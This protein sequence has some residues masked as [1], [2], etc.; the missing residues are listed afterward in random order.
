[1]PT[2]PATTDDQALKQVLRALRRQIRFYVVL[3]SLLYVVLLVGALF[4]IGLALDWLLEP[5]P[6]VRRVIQVGV[7][8]VVVAI[9]GWWGLRRLV[10][11]LSDRAMA[12]AIERRHPEFADKLSTAID[13][14]RPRE[15]GHE[16]HPELVART[17]HA[18]AEIAQ[19]IDIAPILDHLRLRRWGAVIVLLSLSV[20]VL[21]VLAPRVWSTYTD[22]LALSP[23]PWPRRVALTVEGFKPDGQ[24]GFV[25]KVARNSDVPI[26]VNARLT[27]ENIAPER[28]TINYRWAN[29]QMGRDDLVRIGEA[30]ETRDTSQ[31][32]EYLFERISDSVTFRL[33]GG[34]DQIRQ[35]RIEVVERPKVTRLEFVCTYPD[36]LGR[37]PR[38]LTVGPQ[39]EIPE[40]TRVAI[41]GTVNKAIDHV[42]WRI[43]TDDE[44]QLP[45]T[46]TTDKFGHTLVVP[47]NN[48]ALEVSLVDKDGIE[49]QEPFR[50]AIQS[51]VDVAPQ[52]DVQRA[53]I[54]LA[55][56]SIARLPLA[57]RLED[58]YALQRA[59][60]EL[61]IDEGASRELPVELPKVGAD[62]A[63]VEA[64]VDLRQLLESATAEAPFSL[65]P[66]NRLHLTAMA[67]DRYNL[68]SEPHH[69]AGRTVT[70]EV[71]SPEDLVARLAASEQS[72]RQTF[73]AIADKLLVLYG[74]LDAM[75]LET[76]TTATPI[77]NA[78]ESAVGDT[79]EPDD[80]ESAEELVA[81]EA[82]RLAENLR[83]MADETAG[84][85][86]R[87]ADLH[88][89]LGN[90]R[91]DN[92]Q[93]ADRLGNKIAVP[94][95]KLA[96]ELMKRTGDQIAAIRDDATLVTARQGTRE[97]VAEVERLLR[98]MQGLEDYNEVIAMLREIIR[99]QEQIQAK[100]K[101]KEQAEI[102]NL[103]LE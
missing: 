85:A 26:V 50:V 99:Q 98:E 41:S 15:E 6:A 22:R 60:I 93:L 43:A 82:A 40:G 86:T 25:R 18:A 24:G 79:A 87:F 37:A 74:E 32:F 83:Q 36:Y 14:A 23:E 2:L 5:S 63:E 17:R 56:T 38:T 44:E 31:R 20:F 58:D 48:L 65:A 75:E 61:R 9:L 46:A 8:I 89:Q 92:T 3:E 4:W 59:W 80:V 10:V 11:P 55:V 53:G 95:E 68:D 78:S 81:R 45:Q 71:V 12:L 47:R 1:M 88:A 84:V 28:V 67:A 42:A 73:E 57:L 51:R 96:R 33:R 54:G 72:L 30:Q 69:G 94:L 101:A 66:G 19:Q 16:V 27:D 76:L 62:V 35:L 103:L 100:T 77:E 91:V 102:R 39:I 7:G 70:L 29:G 34:D 64:V 52:I 13:L 49:S 90:N 21:A 97:C